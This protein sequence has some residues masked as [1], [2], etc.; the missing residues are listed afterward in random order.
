VFFLVVVFASPAIAIGTVES[1]DGEYSLDAIGSQRLLGAYLHFPDAP[2][3]FPEQD[4]AITA[5]V[6]RLMLEGWLGPQTDYEVNLYLELTRSP[7]AAMGGAFDTV[8]SFDTPYRTPYLAL[9]FWETDAVLGQ[10]GVDRLS[11]GFDAEPLEISVGRMPINHSVTFIF[12]PNDFFA[13]FSATAVNKVYKPGVDALRATLATG[14]LSSIEIDGVLGSDADGVPGWGE[15]A[16]LARLATVAGGFQ[17]ALLGGKLAERWIAGA[18]L[19]GE[20]GP[21]S[22][23]GE[24]HAGFPDTDGVG[25]IDDVDGDGRTADGFHVRLAI[26]ADAVFAWRNATVGAEYMYVSDSGAEPAGYLERAGRYYPDDQPYLGQHYAGLSAG[27]D[28]VGILR[29][30]LAGLLNAADLSG[31]GMATLVYS[32]SDE[33]EF[34]GGVLIPWG[35]R[36]ALDPSQPLAP[37]RLE[38]EFGAMPTMA[39]L[40]TRFY[41]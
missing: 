18:S 32:V 34:V 28:L 10:V 29:L 30:Q 35:S 17:W 23:R 19:Q 36:P 15:S 5:S 25:G 27:M 7:Q 39:F 4:E 16:L 24:G 13:P 12:T 37:V 20:A 2:G 38:S 1:E 33:A 11:V 26:G 3:I 40:E 41:F 6:T 22:I 8:G 9:D 21:I 31:L 14:A